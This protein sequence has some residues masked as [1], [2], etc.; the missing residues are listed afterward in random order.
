MSLSQLLLVFI[1]F[2][3]FRLLPNPLLLFLNI[4]SQPRYLISILFLFLF[5]FV[6]HKIL[7]MISSN[8]KYNLLLLFANTI[9]SSTFPILLYTLKILF[10]TSYFLSS[11][12]LCLIS[13][14]HLSQITSPF[15]SK[16][17]LFLYFLHHLFT[18]LFHHRVFN[19]IQTKYIF[20][21]I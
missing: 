12:I 14:Q 11:I 4:R 6:P 8:S 7:I 10:H 20:R 18:L 3:P 13:F 19:M 5:V 9:S 15:G 21:L 1:S 16:K 2:I 17:L